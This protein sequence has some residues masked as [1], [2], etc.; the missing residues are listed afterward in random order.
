M[1][2]YLIIPRR[3]NN[4]QEMKLLPVSP[5]TEENSRSNIDESENP[6]HSATLVL[7]YWH[8][9]HSSFHVQH[10]QM[11]WANQYL[12]DHLIDIARDN[13]AGQCTTGHSCKDTARDALENLIN[14]RKSYSGGMKKKTM[15]DTKID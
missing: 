11:Q 3:N 14:S 8:Q 10:D 9:L 1:Y 2:S 6:M 13:L 5:N 4:T 7:A 15:I 12:S